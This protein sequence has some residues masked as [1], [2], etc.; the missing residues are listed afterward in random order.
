MRMALEAQYPTL[1]TATLRGKVSASGPEVPGS[2][3]DSTEDPRCMWAW[4]TLN[5]SSWVKRPPA[6]VEQELGMPTHVCRSRH[7]TMVQN[8]EVL[9]K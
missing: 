7:L 8:P 5:L 1:Q 9:A 6:G 3:P 4:C 2:N